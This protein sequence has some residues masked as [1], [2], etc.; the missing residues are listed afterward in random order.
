MGVHHG[1]W[2]EDCQINHHNQSDDLCFLLGKMRFDFS[3]GTLPMKNE[4]I[5]DR[6]DFREKDQNRKEQEMGRK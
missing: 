1:D 3:Q 5:E 6:F 2:D 4:E